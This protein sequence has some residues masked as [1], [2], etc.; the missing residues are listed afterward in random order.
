[1]PRALICVGFFLALHRAKAFADDADGCTS[2]PSPRVCTIDRIPAT[3]MTTEVFKEQYYLRK[4][5]IVQNVATHPEPNSGWT[6]ATL[7]ASYGNVE[8][9]V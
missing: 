4:P 1:M 7:R 3:E 6:T 9:V 8:V 2:P 5:V